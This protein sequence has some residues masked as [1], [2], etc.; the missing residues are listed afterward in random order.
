MATSSRRAPPAPL[1][2]L[3]SRAPP[4]P[5]VIA[6]PPSE[7]DA[8]ASHELEPSAPPIWIDTTAITAGRPC[9]RLPRDVRLCVSPRDPAAAEAHAVLKRVLDRL[10]VAF[11][12]HGDASGPTAAAVRSRLAAVPWRL[13]TP[14]GRVVAPQQSVLRDAETAAPAA[15]A[16]AI[17]GVRHHPVCLTLTVAL[18]GGKGGLGTQLRAQGG[19][20]SSQK[21]TNY[22]ACRDLAGRRLQTVHAAQRVAERAAAAPAREQA[23]QAALAAAIRA[24]REA[25][26]RLEAAAAP[27]PAEAEATTGARARAAEASA[28]AEPGRDDRVNYYRVMDTATKDIQAATRALTSSSFSWPP[29]VPASASSAAGPS[30][31]PATET[32]VTA[33][34]TSS[35]SSSL[36]PSH[37]K[38]KQPAAPKTAAGT[39]RKRN[40]WDDVSSDSEDPEAGH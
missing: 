14:A 15:A 1:A 25:A 38:G 36:P 40:V 28:R 11:A 20:M 7:A 31:R 17:P 26:A 35:S 24:K 21:T 5:L 10:A 8:A 18:C 3:A 27:P 32:I 34:Q 33:P 29:S 13:R 9:A 12:G 19:R 22:E 16:D 39:K 23:K 37:E 2:P 6:M 4:A 30:K